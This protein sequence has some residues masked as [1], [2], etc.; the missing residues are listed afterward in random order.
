MYSVEDKTGAEGFVNNE[1]K[2]RGLSW[3]GTVN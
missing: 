1:F 2:I 3:E